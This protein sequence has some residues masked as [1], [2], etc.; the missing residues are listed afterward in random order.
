VSYGRGDCPHGH[1][2]DTALVVEAGVAWTVLVAPAACVLCE[3]DKVLE[4]F[5]ENSQRADGP[6]LSGLSAHVAQVAE[7]LRR[8]Q[9][10][11][12]AELAPVVAPDAVAQTM[13]RRL[14]DAWV[15]VMD[16]SDREP[17]VVPFKRPEP[18]V[19]FDPKPSPRFA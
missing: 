5:V 18:I 6:V 8:A 15:A 19:P 1:R 7:A 9:A 10:E 4:R 12:K 11:A 3:P 16:A 13:S 14:A 17:E 2:A